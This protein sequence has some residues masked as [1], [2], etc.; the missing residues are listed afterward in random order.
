MNWTE[1]ALKEC[2]TERVPHCG[3]GQYWGWAGLWEGAVLRC[4]LYWGGSQ[5]E[6]E[7]CCGREVLRECSTVG[8]AI[9]WKCSTVE[10]PQWAWSTLWVGLYWGQTHNEGVILRECCTDRGH[11]SDLAAKALPASNYFEAQDNF[12]CVMTIPTSCS[13]WQISGQYP[14]TVHVILLRANLWLCWQPFRNCLGCK[15][16]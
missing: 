14:N 8:G 5:P 13:T 7:P 16:C 15:A 11:L 3:R 2:C 10:G 12:T 9:P 6:G 4:K 1:G